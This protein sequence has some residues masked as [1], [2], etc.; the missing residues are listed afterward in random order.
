MSAYINWSAI[1]VN[2]TAGDDVIW[3]FQVRDLADA[4]V[5][6]TGWTFGFYAE[7]QN[8]DDNTID[9]TDTFTIVDAEEGQAKFTIARA[10]TTGYGATVW[11]GEIWRTNAGNQKRLAAGEWRINSTIRP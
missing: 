5:D 1:T 2:T 3:S 8:D 11:R 9:I 4:V 7:D 10:L 6:I